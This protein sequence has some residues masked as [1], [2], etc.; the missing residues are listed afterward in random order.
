MPRDARALGTRHPITLRRAT[1]RDA[2]FVYRLSEVCMRGYAEQTWGYWDEDAARSSFRVATHRIVQ[3]R[4]R[5]IGC[6]AIE[7]RD[8]ALWLLRI[9][10]LPRYR[11]H[12]IGSA[13]VARAVKRALMRG[14]PLRLKVLRINP[15]VTLYRR[16]GFRIIARTKTRY[17]MEWLPPD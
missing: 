10:L 16:A 15:A 9:Y 13:L 8:D 3:S 11:R 2:E 6:L 17:V 4:E 7:E 1:S 5:D 12:G 14:K